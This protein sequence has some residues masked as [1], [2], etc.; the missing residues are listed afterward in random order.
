MTFDTQATEQPLSIDAAPTRLI[1]LTEVRRL[2]TYSRSTIYTRVSEGL[3]PAPLSLGQRGI[4][5]VSSEIEAVVRAMIAGQTQQ[6]VK[7]L[8][9]KL[10]T[11][12]KAA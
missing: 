6:Q 2:T 11:Q 8:V 5:F 1:K 9:S 7:A 10:I 3:L 12:R 4:A